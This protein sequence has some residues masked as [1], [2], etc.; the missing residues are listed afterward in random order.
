LPENVA[1]FR[2]NPLLK[3]VPSSA[4]L[5]YTPEI[6]NLYPGPIFANT[7]REN[8]VTAWLSPFWQDKGTVHCFGGSVAHMGLAAAEHLGCDPIA[9]G[10]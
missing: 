7:V 10:A 9:R 3:D 1:F 6:V 8:L 2:D 5:Q 4:S